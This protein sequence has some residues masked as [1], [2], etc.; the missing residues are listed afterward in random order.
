MKQEVFG[1]KSSTTSGVPGYGTYAKNKELVVSS[2][3]QRL[4]FLAAQLAAL[5][6]FM[7]RQKSDEG[8]NSQMMLTDERLDRKAA[9]AGFADRNWALGELTRASGDVSRASAAAV[10]F[11]TLLF[12]AFECAP[13]IVKL[14]SDAGPTDVEGSE[15]EKRI[16]AQLTNT[17][18]LNRNRVVRQYR[19]LGS[20]PGR[21]HVRRYMAQKR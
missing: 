14:L 16:I 1:S 3:Q 12:I 15:T 19:F 17:A 8:I 2:K 18:F 6:E 4:E 5:Q 21:R 7:I 9:H 13:L 10:Q 20:R 11:I